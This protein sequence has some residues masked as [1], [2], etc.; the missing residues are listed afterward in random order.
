MM[1]VRRVL[2][3]CFLCVL[4]CGPGV[5]VAGA[6][7]VS[8]RTKR[9]QEIV[10]KVVLMQYAMRSNSDSLLSYVRGAQRSISADNQQRWRMDKWKADKEVPRAEKLA[11][12]AVEG[13]KFVN[14]S[15]DAVHESVTKVLDFFKEALKNT[16]ENSKE[17][18]AIAKA[19]T[20][21]EYA[22]SNVS[23]QLTAAGNVPSHAVQAKEKMDAAASLVKE[24]IQWDPMPQNIRDA[25]S[26]ALEALSEPRKKTEEL[27]SLA[28]QALLTLKSAQE[29]TSDVRLPELQKP[30]APATPQAPANPQGDR[31]SVV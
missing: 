18:P 19:V 11:D 14:E 22:L 10:D 25:L 3:A 8:E 27:N 26:T 12:D 28:N 23:A 7:E 31:K 4:W 21:W 6:E 5:F 20:W 1:S 15:A 9:M 24:K 2:F 16:Q 29:I 30:Q 13:S 17:K